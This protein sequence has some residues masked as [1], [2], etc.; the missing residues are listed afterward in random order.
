MSITAQSSITVDGELLQK[1]GNGHPVAIKESPVT[2]MLINAYLNLKL[3]N[4]F[5][6]IR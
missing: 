5:I 4:A 2:G 1:T 3:Y 6:K